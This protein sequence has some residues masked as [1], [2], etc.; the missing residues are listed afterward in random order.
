MWKGCCLRYHLPKVAHTS[1]LVLNYEF[2]KIIVRKNATYIVFFCY[3]NSIYVKHW[4]QMFSRCLY[5]KDD[6][7]NTNKLVQKQENSRSCSWQLFVRKQTQSGEVK[8]SGLPLCCKHSVLCEPIL[9]LSN[10]LLNCVH[11]I[12][13]FCSERKLT[14]SAVSWSVFAPL[15]K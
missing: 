4:M 13:M 9:L 7:I 3:N 2:W 15:E 12:C 10:N 14:S 6:H 1:L 8:S 5:I 11:F